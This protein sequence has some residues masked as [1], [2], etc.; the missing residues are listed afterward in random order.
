MPFPRA[1]RRRLGLGGEGASWQSVGMTDGAQW[2][3]MQAAW[4]VDPSRKQKIATGTR[5]RFI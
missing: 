3:W 4:A 5:A 1:R 2:P